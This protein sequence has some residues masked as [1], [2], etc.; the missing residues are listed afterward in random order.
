MGIVGNPAQARPFTHA[1]VLDRSMVIAMLRHEDTLFLGPKGQ[2]L[3]TD[4][5]FEHL[6]DLEGYYTF[7][8]VTLSAFGFQT[9]ERDVRMYRTIFS[10]Y[11]R[12]PSDFDAEVLSSVCYMREN[13]CVYYNDPPVNIGDDA[14]DA[15][16][17]TLDGTP[18]TLQS[19]LGALPHKYVFV[20]AFSNS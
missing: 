5:T 10:N 9:T 12:G 13:K 18:T 8:R 17:V 6:T 16:L 15:R 3:F 14:P 2:A 1:D 20:G 7:H 19:V 11:Y 4:G